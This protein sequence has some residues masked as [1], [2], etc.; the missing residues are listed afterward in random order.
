MLSA[1]SH[2]GVP[3]RATCAPQCSHI[4]EHSA[5]FNAFQVV[6][7]KECSAERS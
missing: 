3:I 2:H 7:R 6:A 5:L 1:I 4:T